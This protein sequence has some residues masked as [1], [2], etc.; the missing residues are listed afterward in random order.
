MAC[1]HADSALV[2]VAVTIHVINLQ[3][4]FESYSPIAGSVSWVFGVQSGS[5][6][7]WR[8]VLAVVDSVCAAL[9]KAFLESHTSL[10]NFISL[11]SD[12]SGFCL[13]F[14]F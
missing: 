1:S 9:F 11:S 4:V 12:F 6:H 7:G 14:F 13:I 2:H 5:L 3:F 10:S 8:A